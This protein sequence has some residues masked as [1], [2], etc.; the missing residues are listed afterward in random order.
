[1]RA[2]EGLL[3][4]REDAQA[5]AALARLG[6]DALR[7][8]N[9]SVSPGAVRLV[10][11]LAAF[12]RREP[13]DAQASA[14]RETANPADD[15]DTALS[16]RQVGVTEAARRLGVTVPAVCRWCRLGDLIAWRPAPGAAWIIDE[17]T[18]DALAAA[19]RA[20]GE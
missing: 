6:L 12:A 16:D 2:V 4:S 20:A 3:L 5:A 15:P 10:E 11:A 19:R 13:A 1:M 9:G 17:S 14:I 8:R 18:V 7:Y